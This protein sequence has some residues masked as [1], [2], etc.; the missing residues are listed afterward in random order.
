M[1]V[2]QER[3]LSMRLDQDDACARQAIF[4]LGVLLNLDMLEQ[5]ECV[6]VCEL[7]FFECRAI[8]QAAGWFASQ[9]LFSDDFMMR[10]RQAKTA[11]KRR[12]PTDKEIM[13]VELIRFFIESKVHDHAIYFADS[14]W[15]YVPVLKV[16]VCV[17][18]C[19]RVCVCVCACVCV[20][21]D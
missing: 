7:V 13:V 11:R 2:P 16:C 6:E 15:D 14:L 3:M 19:V 10:A 8:G 4:L 5:E 21:S 9:Y 17:C 1:T 20:C 12:K 18:V